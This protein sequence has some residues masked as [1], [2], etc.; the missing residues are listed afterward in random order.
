MVGDYGDA[1]EVAHGSNHSDVGYGVGE[2]RQ[3]L[4]D[5]SPDVLLGSR[6]R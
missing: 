5:G 2:V 3:D 1:V 4:L 6:P